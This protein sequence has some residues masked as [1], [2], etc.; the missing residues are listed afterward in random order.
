METKPSSPYAELP[1]NVR[2][3][4]ARFDIGQAINGMAASYGLTLAQ[5]E[6]VV[7]SILNDLRGSLLTLASSQIVR[8]TIEPGEK[9]E[10]TA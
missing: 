1:E 8:D 10:Q 9:P 6:L 4:S 7:G 2:L 5:T 3:Q